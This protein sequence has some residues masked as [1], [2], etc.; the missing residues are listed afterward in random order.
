MK[1]STVLV[2]ALAANSLVTMA[3][4]GQGIVVLSG[5]VES[6]GAVYRRP[7]VPV[8][9]SGTTPET[10]G[11]DFMYHDARP[12][13]A[14][15]FSGLGVAH[16]GA[17]F[18]P[19]GPLGIGREFSSVV[20]DACTS[21]EIFGSSVSPSGPNRSEEAYGRAMGMFQFSLASPTGWA[22]SGLAQGNTFN[23][24]AY[25]SV[26]ASFGLRDVNTLT[27]YVNL[28][29]TSTNGVG[30]FFVPFSFGGVLP[31]GTYEL[32][33]SHQSIHTGG[34]TAFGNF[35]TAAGGAP[36][37]SCI[38]SVFSL[39]PSPGALGLLGVAGVLGARRR[40]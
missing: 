13:Q 1:H 31:A 22:W 29:D 17:T 33:W 4:F 15:G 9:N 27:S 6:A 5:S 20:L 3:T 16:L 11:H 12:F 34:I 26:T 19:S 40:R 21:A 18:S 14:G 39:V 32:T 2:M 30:D 35:P 10:M 8:G 25:H 28:T 23:T 7:V 36:L 24:G 37:V 38:P